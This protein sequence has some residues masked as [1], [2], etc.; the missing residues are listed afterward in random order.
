MT[1]NISLPNGPLNGGVDAAPALSTATPLSQALESARPIAL[2]INFARITGDAKAAVF[3]SQLVYWTRRGTEVLANDG[4]IFKTREQW[5]AET[6]LSRHEQL[7]VQTRLIDLGLIES[8]RTGAPARNCYRVVASVLGSKLAQLVKAEPVQWSLLDIQ[9]GDNNVRAMLGRQFAFYRLLSDITSSTTNAIYLSR[10]IAIQ[11]RFGAENTSPAQLPWD[12]Q[13]FRMAIDSTQLDT[14]LTP[15]QQRESK[16]KLCQLGLL[17]EAVLTHPRKQHFLRVNFTALIQ[18]ITGFLNKHDNNTSLVKP[19]KWLSLNHFPDFTE[20]P[21]SV[22]LVKPRKRVSLTRFPDFTE[23]RAPSALP[24]QDSSADC[25]ECENRTTRNADLSNL[26]VRFSQASRPVLAPPPSDFRTQNR[27]FF[28][29]SPNTYARTTHAQRLQGDYKQNTT[30]TTPISPKPSVDA[31]LCA[32]PAEPPVVVVVTNDAQNPGPNSSAQACS[33][34]DG[35][36]LIWPSEV[37]AQTQASALRILAPLAKTGQLKDAQNL[38][39]EWAGCML[40]YRIGSPLAYLRRLVHTHTNDP[41]GL[42][43]ERALL[44]QQQRRDQLARQKRLDDLSKRQLD[45][46]DPTQ[47]PAGGPTGAPEAP[48][49]AIELSDAAKAALLQLRASIP[50]RSP[51]SDDQP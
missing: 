40:A 21:N 18:A 8:L 43:W 49:T 36:V 12:A 32:R 6:G 38:I 14:G 28:G 45:A 24:H 5:E 25:A 3:L 37:D 26:D 10:A 13:W 33:A 48:N 29:Q 51:K 16:H 22:S 4:W 1:E 17:K 19:R 30:T 39:D 27:S 31:G 41:A 50:K 42:V 11:Q 34:L 44:V 47:R 23:G 9:Q 20:H 15:A 46:A 35:R 2:N 7:S